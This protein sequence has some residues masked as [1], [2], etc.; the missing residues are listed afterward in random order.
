V[1]AAA[2][3]SLGQR[4]ARADIPKLE[5]VLNDSNDG[6]RFMATA[7]II[8]LSEPPAKPALRKSKKAATPPA[9]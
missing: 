7:A 8:R 5:P 1:R 2:A 4:A 3:R 9:K 6:V